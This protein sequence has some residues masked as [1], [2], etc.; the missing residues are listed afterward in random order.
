[1]SVHMSTNTPVHMSID[2]YRSNLELIVEGEEMQD[3]HHQYLGG[4]EAYTKK[5]HNARTLYMRADMCAGMCADICADMC[6]DMCA[7]LCR[8]VCADM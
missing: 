1:M 4:P 5:V 7:G 6:A 2:T 3:S 8:H